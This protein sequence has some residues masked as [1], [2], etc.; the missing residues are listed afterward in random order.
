MSGTTAYRSTTGSGS[1]IKRD[2][3]SVSAAAAKF[4][5]NSDLDI[6]YTRTRA[7]R[8]VGGRG[9]V[10]TG[11]APIERESSEVPF[12]GSFS[13][14]GQRRARGQHVQSR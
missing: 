5:I 12:G 3:H 1:A 7:R 2:I 14:T 9:T 11:W 8:L 13:S 10:E 6:L 4:H